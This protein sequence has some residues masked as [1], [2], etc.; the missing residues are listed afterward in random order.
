[1]GTDCSNISKVSPITFSE[2]RSQTFAIVLSRSDP[3]LDLDHCDSSC[4]HTRPIGLNWK[5]HIGRPRQACILIV[6][7][8]KETHSRHTRRH[9]TKLYL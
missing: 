9:S 3:A 8:R 6:K 7:R 1:L 5:R 2:G 4:S